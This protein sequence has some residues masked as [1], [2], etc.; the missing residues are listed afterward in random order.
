MKL[1]MIIGLFIFCVLGV[2]AQKKGD[3]KA[4]V[5][6]TWIKLNNSPQ[7]VKGVLYEVGD[8]SIFVVE[9]QLN[10]EAREYSFSHINLLKV[11]R[12]RSII[13]GAIAG[14]AIGGGAG[15][16]T[17]LAL[18]D[19]AGLFTGA[20][21]ASLGL[22]F[23]VFGGGI[24][25]LAGSIKD[26][27]PIDRSFDN[28]NKYRRPLQNYSFLKEEIVA[29]NKFKHRG[30]V[31]FSAGL[32]FARNEFAFD[33]PVGDYNGMETTGFCS[34]AIIG[35]RVKEQIGVNVSVRTSQ[36]SAVDNSQTEMFWNL[37]AITAGPVLSLPISEKSRF[38]F[39]PAIGFANASLYA[40]NNEVYTGGGFAVNISGAL[41]YDISKRWV[42]SV[43]SGYLSSKQ[44]F[45][46]GGN[47][48]ANDM[49][50]QLGLAYKFGKKSL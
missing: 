12:D 44:E 2:S 37:D 28:F 36:Y 16:V 15:V 32:S 19:K 24:G 33:V 47:G 35:Y 29:P 42:G 22:A 50:V 5:Y 26:R 21:S 31:G 8:S 27:F 1:L 11:R 49:D 14:S 9:S 30:Y 43:S 45:K 41:V 3:R 4:K 13:R 25:I 40:D 7:I 23:G 38:D 46:Q 39:S 6:K 17:G 20:I 10:P 18:A 34:K 48:K